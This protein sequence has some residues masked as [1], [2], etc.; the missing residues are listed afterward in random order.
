MADKE[1]EKMVEKASP[2]SKTAVNV[3]KAFLFGGGICLIG[4]FISFFLKKTALPEEGVKSLVPMILIFITAFLTGI[5]VYNKIAKHGGAGT[6]VPIT[7]FANA[8]V[9]PALE[10]QSEGKILGTGAKIFTIAGPVIA[11]GSF[12]AFIYGLV[13]WVYTIFV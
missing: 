10:F 1:Y 9:A 7:G 13:Y 11:Y 2:G 6:L 5:G 12:A 3:L 8:V 4:E